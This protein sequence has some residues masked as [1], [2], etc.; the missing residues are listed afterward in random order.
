MKVQVSLAIAASAAA[1]ILTPSRAWTTT[2]SPGLVAHEWGTFTSLQDDEGRVVEGM[3]HEEE[4]LPSFVHGRDR[5]L[6]L[7][8]AVLS[9]LTAQQAHPVSAL[10][11]DD[12]PHLPRHHLP[13]KA[14]D[15]DVSAL[16]VTQKME[17]PVIY[18]YSDQPR[19]VQV[20]VDFPGGII[21]QYYPDATS[22]SPALG[23]AEAVANGHVEWNLLVSA[24]PLV[25]PPVTPDSIWQ[26]SREVASNFI[27][28]QG[29]NEKLLFYRGLGK[30]E[31]PLRIPSTPNGGFLI[32]N[33]SDERVPDVFLLRNNGKT[34]SVRALGAITAH[35]QIELPASAFDGTEAEAPESIDAYVDHASSLVEQALRRS[36]LYADEARAMVNT[37][38]RSYFRAAGTR[39]LYVLPRE[40]TD[41]LLPLHL[42]PQPREL[43]RTLV[44][45]VELQTGQEV[46]SVL[47]KIGQ[48][49]SLESLSLGRFAE[50]KLRLIRHKAQAQG[51]SSETLVQIDRLVKQAQEE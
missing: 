22:F 13:C 35:G 51:A 27:S 19:Q 1:L 17:T 7:Q 39:V 40:W 49:R 44:G 48:N 45:R 10:P 41:N 5:S 34:A 37:W 36:G 11:S 50:S 14:C 6:N 18:F 29:E 21:T 33:Q 20:A 23:K 9:F 32:R 38:K 4:G 28:A 42:N 8:K 46:E 15:F 43:V 2:A 12:T 30:F 47:S 3:H 26:P 24:D 31:T 16:A 25:V